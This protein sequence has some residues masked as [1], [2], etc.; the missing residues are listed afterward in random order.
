MPENMVDL[1]VEAM[2]RAAATGKIGDGKIFRSKAAD[3]VRIRHR[4]RRDAL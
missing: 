3:A 4:D 2:I 1:V